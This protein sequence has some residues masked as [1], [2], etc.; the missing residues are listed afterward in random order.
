MFARAGGFDGGIES[1]EVRLAG[2]IL[3]GFDD[4]SNLFRAEPHLLNPGGRKPDLRAD[5]LHARD[6]LLNGLGAFAGV[7]GGFSRIA[8]HRERVMGHLFNGGAD[9]GGDQRHLADG[10]GLFLSAACNHVN[11]VRHFFHRRR[12]I[13]DRFSLGGDPS[14]HLLNGQGNLRSRFARLAC[15]VR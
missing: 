3:D 7:S 10:I 12:G 9:A 5:G 6:G 15:R 4:G 11:G 2:N 13:V 1:E 14:G 8:R